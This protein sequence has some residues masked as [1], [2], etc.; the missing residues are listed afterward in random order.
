MYDRVC[1]VVF[2]IGKCGTWACAVKTQTARRLYSW[3]QTLHPCRLLI[4]FTLT[5]II[6]P[7]SYS[8]RRPKSIIEKSNHRKENI[9]ETRSEI[10]INLN[11]FD[12]REDSLKR[13]Q[14]QNKKKTF[15]IMT[16]VFGIILLISEKKKQFKSLCH[17]CSSVLSQ[18]GAGMGSLQNT[19]EL[20][21]L[22][23]PTARMAACQ[24]HRDFLTP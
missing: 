17:L 18:T 13:K 16:Q 10:K 9:C 5:I 3:E 19:L 4:L 8:E 7:P 2:T 21:R 20:A 12:F 15:Q 6:S 14:K 23:M 1:T 11:Q 22:K 24:V